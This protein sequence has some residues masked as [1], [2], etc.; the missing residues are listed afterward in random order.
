[1]WRML[2]ISTAC[3]LVAAAGASTAAG[4]PS[5]ALTA[6]ERC[7][8]ALHAGERSAVF[9]GTM[10]SLR[11]GA[12]RMEMRFD[13]YRRV[14]GATTF[15]HVS[16]LGLGVWN[17]AARGVR[18]FRFRQKV[19]NLSA[20]AAY[21]AL[22]SFRWTD[23]EG[24]QLSRTSQVTPVCWQPDLRPDLRIARVTG[25]RG[26]AESA[27]YL[28]TVRNEG[29]TAAS[30]FAVGLE[31]NGAPVLPAP[32]LPMLEPGGRQ[33]VAFTGPRCAAGS[34]V[35]ATVDVDNRVDEADEADDALLVPCPLP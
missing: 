28:V 4:R 23:A 21:R 6:V 8:A 19:A 9:S 17:A 30:A 15:V 26:P 29:R 34:A 22:V 20:P 5:R 14:K 25:T 1:M 27:L 2:L 7:H 33:A 3:A 11:R 12:D 35:R 10:R 31:V 13:L 24:R 16:A 32:V 18:R